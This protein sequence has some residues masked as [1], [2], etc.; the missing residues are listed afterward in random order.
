[1]ENRLK[2]L[3]ALLI[4]PFLALVLTACPDNGDAEGDES[5]PPAVEGSEEVEGEDEN[6]ED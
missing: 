2:K 6:G 3:L 1:M 5:T 4:V